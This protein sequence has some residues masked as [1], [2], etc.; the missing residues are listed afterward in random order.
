MR[1]TEPL[2]LL[3]ET[4]LRL[5]WLPAR[6]ATGNWSMTVIAKG[7]F[8]LVPDG[9][10]TW[11]D[12]GEALMPT[13]GVVLG[14]NPD[15]APLAPSDYAV[16]KPCTEITLKATC[17]APGGT[18]AGAVRV[19]LRFG[20]LSK[21]L[22]VTGR[23]R[24]VSGGR[25]TPSP[26]EPFTALPLDWRYAFGGP[27]DPA[28]PHGIG[29]VPLRTADGASIQPLPR[30]QWPDDAPSSP[31]QRLVPAGFGPLGRT[32]AGRNAPR[33]TFGGSYVSMQWPG[34][35]PDFDWEHFCEAPADQRL[36]GFADGD[37]EIVL[38]N[39]HPTI[40]AL[41]FALP[42][43]RVRALVGYAAGALEA[44][45]A[46]GTATFPFVDVDMRLD[47]IHVDADAGLVAL[48]W[49]G[50]AVVARPDLAD[51]ASIYLATEEVAE[52][53][54]STAAHL[55][56]HHRLLAARLTPTPAVADVVDAGPTEVDV[57]RSVDEGPDIAAAPAGVAAPG[58][59]AV[60]AVDAVD[61]DD[62]L[63]EMMATALA[64]GREQLR[65]AGVSEEVVV[66]LGPDMDFSAFMSALA[67]DR[68]LP[69]PASVDVEEMER[70]SRRAI[71]DEAV[72]QGAD[73]QAIDAL[74]ADL[75][76]PEDPDL[77]DPPEPDPME[78]TRERVMAHH[79]AGG[80][81]AEEDLSG[82]DLSGLDLRGANF[83]GA[84]LDGAD[85]SRAGLAGA[86]FSDASLAGAR[87]LEADLEGADLARADLSDASLAGARLCGAVLD[88]V[89]LRRADLE[90]CAAS[91]A[92]GR[93]ADLS[94][95]RLARSVWDEAVLPDA[96]L[97]GTRLDGASFRRADLSAGSIEGARGEGVTFDE[98]DLTRLAAGRGVVLP[99]AS[100]AFARGEF[101]TFTNALLDRADLSYAD[102]GRAD[103]SG[104]SLREADL[105]AIDL[106]SGTLAGADLTRA[107]LAAADLFEASLAGATL[108]ETRLDGANAFAAEFWEAEVAR[109]SFLGAN[110][111]RT[112]LVHPDFRALFR[113]NTYDDRRT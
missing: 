51:V 88:N 54:A 35:P 60:D 12:P 40:P 29:A 107:N 5:G 38:G 26:P 113:A 76:R 42:G 24:W 28:N 44:H 85:L 95:A 80:G 18:P 49:R 39:M 13:G 10:A 90:G 93:L 77:P 59:P 7:T 3:T 61:E 21:T 78:W 112:K 84:L 4:P 102:F 16:Y 55:A 74:F 17:F 57:V 79:A 89:R 50:L 14:D 31:S 97:S 101:A 27:G 48:T 22:V 105:G 81:F 68:G 96:D 56:A 47:T 15:G 43:V 53:A 30:I 73:P 66:L 20:P 52:P 6:T 45:P 86:R 100:F 36:A 33:G 46:R 111:E 58:S 23:R 87:L 83:A 67:R 106:R 32:V 9:V 63:D 75:D 98:A 25:Y 70:A 92:A 71:R 19:G 2:R 62:G 94:E 104:A 109:S 41:R 91:R 72:R 82:L 37:E 1:R 103:L 8:R 11:A 108:F 110:I 69:E 65:K 34:L 64:E 99:G